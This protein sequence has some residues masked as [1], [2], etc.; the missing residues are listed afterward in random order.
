MVAWDIA[1]QDCFCDEVVIEVRG[2]AGVLIK[3]PMAI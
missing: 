1:A 3:H 2:L